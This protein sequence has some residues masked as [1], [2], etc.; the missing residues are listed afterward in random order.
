MNE[1]GDQVEARMLQDL[2]EQLDDPPR[3]DAPSGT[4]LFRKGD[5]MN[6]I[7]VILNGAVDLYLDID[8]QEVVFH[9]QTA[10]K[11]VGL[12]SLTQRSKAFF[13]AR[14]TAP[15]QLLSISFDELD[16]A[17]QQSQALRESF[18]TV[19]LQSMARRT[20]RLVDLQH[21]VVA[22][23]MSLSRERDAL[24]RTLHELQQAQAFL[25]ETEK[26][27]TLGQLA[28]GVA[29]ELNN[30]TAAIGR[31]ADFIQED[32]LALANELPDGAAFHAMLTRALNQKPVST[33]EQR[34]HRR[35]L[36]GVL[37]DETMAAQLVEMGI[38]E[39]EEY[40]QLAADLPG[41]D[42]EKIVRL[43]RYHQL[44]GAVRNIARCA[45]RIAD[46]VNSLRSYSRSDTS[47]AV[48]FDVHDGI[49][50]TLRLFSNRL[51]DMEVERQYA[52]LPPITGN[53]GALNQVWTNLIAN[54][55]DAMD[56]RGRLTIA[57]SREANG[58]TARIVDNGPGIAPEHRDKIFELRFTTRQG[59]VEFGMGL[60][61][62][63]SQNIV[64]RHGGRISVQ[65]K[66]GHTEF[67][68]SLPLSPADSVS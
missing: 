33:R 16:R 35:A 4:V 5:P 52:D 57:T 66:P 24:S 31:A 62:T 65:S 58:I 22:L 48:E 10:G 37:R 32:L 11:I 7:Y 26:M 14:T 67:C 2:L 49:E 38:H 50:D 3:L 23:N 8:E 13:S 36:A 39:Q 43:T 59:R 18:I 29:H 47:A 41:N 44:G 30:P 34:E 25:V 28:A 9:K 56:N 55:L 46:L 19:L 15:A 64:S 1:P 53:P 61:L 6:G 17:L 40:R 42:P 21:E 60:G 63:I 54:A 68:V 51:R 12:L 45:E 20:M 27:A